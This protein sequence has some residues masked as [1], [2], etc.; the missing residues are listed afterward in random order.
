MSML[1]VPLYGI[2]VREIDTNGEFVEETQSGIGSPWILYS[3]HAGVEETRRVATQLAGR[4][5]NDGLMIV[6]II[7]TL[8]DLDIV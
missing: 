4:Y 3:K 8:V 5:G 6:Q 7:D 2:F 1:G